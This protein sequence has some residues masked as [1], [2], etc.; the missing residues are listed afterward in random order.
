MRWLLLL[1][2][3]VSACG[4]KKPP[5]PKNEFEAFERRFVLEYKVL[6]D[7]MRKRGKAIADK[8]VPSTY[9]AVYIGPPGVIVDRKIVATLAELDTKRAEIAAAIAANAQLLPTIGYTG[10][11]TTF[12]LD[13]QDPSVATSALRLLVGRKTTINVTRPY[14]P[15]LPRATE[16]ICSDATFG[17]Q[18]NAEVEN[19][20]LSLLLDKDQI[21]IG[22]SR[23]NE[24]Q[25]IPDRAGERDLDKLAVTLRDHKSTAFFA[26]RTDIELAATHAKAGDVIDALRAA[27]EAGFLDITILQRGQLSANPQL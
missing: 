10:A 5:P 3:V 16:L 8:D 25:A 26:D 18:P 27:C 17:D 11:V 2:V 6:A 24:Y 15:A 20:H 4:D 23:I 12:D 22:L 7:A 21:W 19:P 9:R 13:A 1:L 14:D